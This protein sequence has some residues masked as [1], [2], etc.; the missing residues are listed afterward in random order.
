MTHIH[1]RVEFKTISK[2]TLFDNEFSSGQYIYTREAESTNLIA[3]LG[4]ELLYLSLVADNLMR[5]A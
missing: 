3:E 1:R 5:R 4:E 2:S